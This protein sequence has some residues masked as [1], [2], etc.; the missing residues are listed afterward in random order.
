MGKD[1]L[2]FNMTVGVIVA[3]SLFAVFCGFALC[4]HVYGSHWANPD[5]QR[6]IH[7]SN[8]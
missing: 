4:L 5:V 1:E 8:N 6:A 7:S 3:L 2:V